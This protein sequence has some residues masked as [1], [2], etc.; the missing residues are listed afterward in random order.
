MLHRVNLNLISCKTF[1]QNARNDACQLCIEGLIPQIFGN[2]S[3]FVLLKIKSTVCL[4]WSCNRA[5]N[6]SAGLY[7]RNDIGDNP[8]GE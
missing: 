7:R 1:V 2:S 8:A 3:A 5:L 6:P 4:D